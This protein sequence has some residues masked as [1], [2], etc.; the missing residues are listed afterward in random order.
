MEN[1]TASLA[2]IAIAL[3]LPVGAH[4]QAYVGA[5]VGRFWR[6]ASPT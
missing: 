6:A 3:A 5:S 4:A 1:R 2:L